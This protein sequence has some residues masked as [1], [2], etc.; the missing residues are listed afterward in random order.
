M[1]V[2]LLD[3]NKDYSERF[4]YYLEKNFNIEIDICDNEKVWLSIL[5]SKSFDIVLCDVSF[6]ISLSNNVLDDTAFAFLSETNEIVGNTDT[7]FR[8]QG[9]TKLHKE[10]CYCYEKKKN[11]VVKTDKQVEQSEQN[12]NIITFLPVHGGAGSSSMAAACA[13]VLSLYSEVLY[14]NMEQIPSDFAFFESDDKNS[15]CLSDISTHMDTRYTTQSITNELSKTIRKDKKFNTGNL[16]YIQGLK[17]IKDTLNAKIIEEMVKILR[18]QFHYRYVV[19]DGDFV[20]GSFLEKLIY[21]SDKVVLVS[22][23]SDIAKEK[24]LKIKRYIK[25]LDREGEGDVP[26]CYILFNQYYGSDSFFTQNDDMQILGSFPRYRT[27]NQTRIS[28]YDIISQVMAKKEVFD[29]IK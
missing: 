16:Y 27:N 9:I 4:K 14:I 8:Y 1:K 23:D 7:I 6:D 10:I 28:S 17:N 25:I 5:Q 18:Q 13:A 22:S 11:R 20:V 19:I 12:V 21:N 2:L 15:K 3:K 26:P 29:K 24:L